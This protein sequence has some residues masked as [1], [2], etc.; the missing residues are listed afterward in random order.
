MSSEREVQNYQD[1][2]QSPDV[3]FL[4][5]PNITYKRK[6]EDKTNMVPRL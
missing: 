3:L 2:K 1:K 6:Y 5:S 4:S